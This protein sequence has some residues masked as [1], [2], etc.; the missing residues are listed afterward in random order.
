[1]KQL[2]GTFTLDMSTS[3]SYVIAVNRCDVEAVL[4]LRCKSIFCKFHTFHCRVPRMIVFYAASTC[5]F[6][7]FP[8][9][10]PKR[11]LKN[12]AGTCT[13]IIVL[14]QGLAA[15]QQFFSMHLGGS[16]SNPA[17]ISSL[18]HPIPASPLLTDP[19]YVRRHG[20]FLAPLCKP[21]RIQTMV[22]PLF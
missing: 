21:L 13:K 4:A 3:G 10:G 9:F 8:D 5:L 12:A 6:T 11:I 22:S 18:L 17:L 16:W 19:P 20:G 7:Y 14:V 1:M 2:N 15:L